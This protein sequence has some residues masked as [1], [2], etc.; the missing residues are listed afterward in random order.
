MFGAKPDHNLF[1]VLLSLSTWRVTGAG[2]PGGRR[3]EC[4]LY[5]MSLEMK[6][7]G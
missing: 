6:V 5:F 7:V 4:I 3:A 2:K 1:N